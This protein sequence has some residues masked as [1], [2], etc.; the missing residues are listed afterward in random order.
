MQDFSIL[1]TQLYHDQ[2]KV[3]ESFEKNLP[4]PMEV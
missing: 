4:Q 1:R 3:K 2:S